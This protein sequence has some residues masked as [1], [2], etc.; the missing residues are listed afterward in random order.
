MPSV[1]HVS[2]LYHSPAADAHGVGRLTLLASQALEQREVLGAAVGLVEDVKLLLGQA[3]AAVT[4]VAV[5]AEGAAH[6]I[7]RV[8]ATDGVLAVR[9]IVAAHATHAVTAA[10]RRFAVLAVGAAVAI[11]ATLAEHAMNAARAALATKATQVLLGRAKL[12]LQTRQF[13]VEFGTIHGARLYRKPTAGS[14][15][16]LQVDGRFL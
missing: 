9:A 7:R 15:Q 1:V 5:G 2:Q 8:G 6:E 14:R 11:A 10:G 16:R 4:V 3:H 12:P 13:G